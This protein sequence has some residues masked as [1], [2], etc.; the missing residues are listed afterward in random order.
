MSVKSRP[1]NTSS[2]HASAAA[3]LSENAQKREKRGILVAAKS[4][5][6]DAERECALTTELLQAIA[7]YRRECVFVAT[8]QIAVLCGAVSQASDENSAKFAEAQSI[9]L[10]HE[11]EKIRQRE[12]RKHAREWVRSFEKFRKEH[13]I[14]PARRALVESWRS[15][16]SEGS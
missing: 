1:Q 8:S 2:A 15:K 12:E 11:A 9:V 6:A 10:N 5:L 16:S 4:R 3:P 14:N 7:K 13:P